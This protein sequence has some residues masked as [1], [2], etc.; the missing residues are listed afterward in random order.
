MDAARST[1]VAQAT[2]VELVAGGRLDTVLGQTA[3]ALARR[4]DAGASTMARD[5]A[6][7]EKVMVAA[8]RGVQVGPET[9]LDELRA[10]RDAKRG[11]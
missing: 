11:A 9:R 2:E 5:A 1:A 3:L 10:R 4:I 8:L 6:Q 7:L